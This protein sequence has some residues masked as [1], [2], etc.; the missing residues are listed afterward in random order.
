MFCIKLTLITKGEK[1]KQNKR[2]EIV[3]S[4]SKIYAQK[5][6]GGCKTRK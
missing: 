3:G 6:T 5:G 2:N 1:L 4:T